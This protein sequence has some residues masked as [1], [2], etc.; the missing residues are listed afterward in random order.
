MA[1]TS[2]HLLI[3]LERDAKQAQDE[4]NYDDTL[5]GAWCQFLN[6][7]H[8]KRRRLE[9]KIDL[10]GYGVFICQQACE[11]QHRDLDECFSTE[12]RLWFYGIH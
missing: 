1:P 9:L 3:P 11:R 8:Y 4:A 12:E 7:C 2:L 5:P 6:G 10:L